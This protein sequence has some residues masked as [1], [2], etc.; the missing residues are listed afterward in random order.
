MHFP[1]RC[2]TALGTSGLILFLFVS[3]ASA[4]T[5]VNIYPGTDIP[6]VVD[7]NPAGTKFIIHPGTY[8]VGTIT[9]KSGDS[10]V[11]A[12]SCAPPKTACT[13]ILNGSVLLTSFQKTGT[14]YHVGGQTQ[15]NAVTVPSTKCQPMNPGYPIAYPGCVYPEDLF[16]DNKPLVHVLSLS[17]VGPGTWYF[18]YPTQTIYFYDNPSGHKVEASVRVSAFA[19]GP[20]NNV[21]I[22]G[23]TMEKYA[24]PIMGGVVGGIRIGYYGSPSKGANWVVKYNEI[25]LS[26]SNGVVPNFGWRVLYNYIHDN[27]DLGIGGGIGGGNAD[28]SGTTNSN[29]L[30][31]GN[32][33]AYNNFAHVSP[34]YGAG[35][36]KLVF[37]YGPVFRR[38][39]VHNNQGS[40]FHDDLGLRGALYDGN[41][42]A[43]N[44]EQGIFHE[45]SYAST[46]RNNK[47][48][49]NGYI[50]P[51]NT[52][53]LYGANVLSSTSNY[54]DVYCNTVEISAQGGNGLDMITQPRTDTP[55]IPQGNTFH[56]NTVVFDGN[57]GFTGGARSASTDAKEVNFFSLNAFDYNSYHLPSLSRKA[58]AW[59]D[60]YNTFAE[61]QALGQDVHGSA[62]VDYRASIPDVS[63]TS[64]ADQTSLSGTVPIAATAT[65]PASI[66]KVEFL[67]DWKVVKTDTAAPYSYSWGT[68]SYK[69]GAHTVTA[70]AY[71]SNGTHACYAV[72]LYVK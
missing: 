30:V 9:P 51:N 60:K 4:G 29:L 45:I 41:I 23:L 58:F 54:L 15:N 17:L 32:D 20:A 69:A 16:F 67:V 70:I 50:H 48:L 52:F 47:L 72:T 56:H 36:N 13:A 19:Y 39:Y 68:G 44:T 7:A 25:R 5:I 21:I 35:G 43:D 46:V 62:D 65:D 64:P 49:R 14:Y 37:T 22:Q 71:S 2:R 38:N 27:G 24:T 8:R 3:L 59:D 1:P 11:G 55:I 10:F 42:S 61:F 53:W 63:I 33:I 18:D 40:G 28:G 31:E 26:H 66:T 34:H 6:N 12:T 57:S